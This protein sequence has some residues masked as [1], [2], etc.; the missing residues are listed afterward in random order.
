[1]IDIVNHPFD[2]GN[3]P[4]QDVI[5]HS[6]RGAWR[7]PYRALT[8]GYSAEDVG[9]TVTRALVASIRKE[10]GMPWAPVLAAGIEQSRAAGSRE[11]W[12]A[13]RRQALR[14][15]GGVAGLRLALE[16]AEGL[17]ADETG[18]P[19][20]DAETALVMTTLER[21]VEAR[22]LAPARRELVER[23]GGYE[24]EQEYEHSVLDY[25][26]IQQ[27]ADSVIQHRD[28]KGLRAPRQSRRKSTAELL[29]EPLK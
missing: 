8:S 23:L 28:G 19:A 15:S 2:N 24:A 25:V 20:T 12:E 10:G 5:P 22:V 13:A 4:D 17:L 27:I 26:P 11:P 21:E 6:I 16:Q 7:R 1:V 3:V 9:R 14:R 18:R 29:E